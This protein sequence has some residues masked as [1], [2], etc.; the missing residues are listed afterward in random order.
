MKFETKISGT[1]VTDFNI[2]P[3]FSNQIIW[4][5]EAIKII[6]R[7]E[8][9]NFLLDGFRF[10]KGNE[11]EGDWGAVLDYD[12]IYKLSILENYPEYEKEMTNYFGKTWYTQYIRFNH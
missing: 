7:Q 8:T 3:I 6:K 2:T 9:M 1:K 5:S 12:T 4:L 10:S 11:K